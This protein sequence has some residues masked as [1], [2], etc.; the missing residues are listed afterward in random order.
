MSAGSQV[1]IGGATGGGVDANGNPNVGFGSLLSPFSEQF[2]APTGVTEQNDPG[3]QFRLKQGMDALQNSAAARGGLL[4]GGTGRALNDYAQNSASNE[5]SNVYNRAMQEY[6]NRYNIFTGN[7]TNQFNKLADIA[8]L[9]QTSAGQLSTAGLQT[10]NEVGNTLLGT[11]GQM[12]ND[13]NL[14]GGARASGYVGAAN[15][16]SGALSNLGNLYYMSQLMH[17]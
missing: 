3:Y 13:L 11:A 12:G 4:S 5:Y 15:A 16:A 17:A 9:G 10:G 7:Q 6:L 1:P 14:A 2:S 8:G